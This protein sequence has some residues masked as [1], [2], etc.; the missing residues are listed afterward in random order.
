LSVP[1]RP[2]GFTLEI[3]GRCH[4]DCLYCYNHWRGPDATL[5]AEL[6]PA[7]LVALALRLA[8]AA[9]RSRV[10]LSGGEPLLRQDWAEIAGRLR[11]AG[12]GVGLTTDGG[13]VDRD[14]A[15]SLARLGV[16][17]VQV[18]LLSGR[19][20]PHDRLKGRRGAHAE[21]LIGLAELFRAEVP[22]S[23]AFIATAANRGEEA[24][25]AETAFA[26]GARSLAFHRLCTAGAAARNLAGLLLSPQAVADSAAALAAGARPG[27]GYFVAI[28][29]PRCL[30]GSTAA[31]A[32]RGTG[33]CAAAGC[34]PGLCL[35]PNGQLR[36]CAA[37]AEGLGDVA[38]SDPA[39]LLAAHRAAMA[40]RIATGPCQGC[41]E[42]ELCRG[43]CL[44]SS[45]GASLA[46]VDPLAAG[47]PAG[48]AG[49]RD[50]GQA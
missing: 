1:R 18:T 41:G 36:A 46:G 12:L 8:A 38:V 40:A 49:R 45:R 2:R 30:P 27:L 17:P 23:V 44:A 42:W 34:E 13:P 25:V 50:A 15:R 22:T 47:A 7:E 11:A 3:T 20:E 24:G 5:P 43:G 16:A 6:G 48:A 4:R 9:G 39:G 28:A 19:P 37:L 31:A 10:D 26:L 14:T 32:P 29:L 33:T 21:A 35:G